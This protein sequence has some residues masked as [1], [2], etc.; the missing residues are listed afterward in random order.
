[1][2]T[3]AGDEPDGSFFQGE[4]FEV[5]A[6]NEDTSGHQVDLVHAGPMQMSNGGVHD[7]RVGFDFGVAAP[8]AK[9][10]VEIEEPKPMLVRVNPKCG[11]V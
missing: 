9:V 5:V 1:M 11:V 8:R 4:G 3:T 6:L 7:I 10:K 2:T